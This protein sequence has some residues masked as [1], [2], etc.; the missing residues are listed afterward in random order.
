MY[1]PFSISSLRSLPSNEYKIVYSASTSADS[2][3]VSE[4]HI[5]QADLYKLSMSKKL[6]RVRW[7]LE[8]LS[9]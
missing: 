8:Q 5:A 2:I 6:S 3:C 9:L 7:G 4:R 1:A